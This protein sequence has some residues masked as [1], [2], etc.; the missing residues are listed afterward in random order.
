MTGTGAEVSE[1]KKVLGALD[2]VMLGLGAMIGTGIFVLTGI[3]AVAAGPALAISFILAASA[4]ALAALCYAEFASMIPVAGSAYTYSYATLGELIAWI[5]GWSLIAEYG[6]ATAA[7]SVGWS[8]YFQALLAGFGLQLPAALSAAPGVDAAGTTTLFNLPAFVIMMVITAIL[9][10]GIHESKR[11]NNL[12]VIIKLIVVIL[13]IAVGGWYV[14][15]ENFEPYAPHGLSGIVSA[16]AL[17]FFAFLGFDAVSSAAEE[18]RRPQRDLPIG[19]IGSLL[20]C[21]LL[22]A[23]VAT[24]ATGI[25]PF[26]DFKGVDEPI[27]LV[28]QRAG[29]DW[30]AGLVSLAAVSGMMT[31]IL[32]MGYG[33]T[34]VVFAMS[35][36]GLLPGWLSRIDQRQVPVASTWLLGT[37]SA[38]IAATI[39]LTT[40]AELINM[41][42]LLAFTIISLSVP[43]LRRTRPDL[44]RAFR[45]PLPWVLGPLSVVICLILMLN[46]A[47]ETWFAFLIWLLVGLA[48]YFG[49]SRH[50]ARHENLY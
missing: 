46:L 8:G 26:Q 42:T 43:I 21:A 9:A 29:I 10:L 16:A 25:V 5:V 6:L 38:L 35:R 40:L 14:K 24:V 4:C 15:P 20:I 41:G 47:F 31:V 3:G 12:L 7:V 48:C 32:V 2:L 45:V 23:L 22:Y 1:L 27:A 19:L 18:V 36:D 39:P 49:Y 17:V 37:I 50:H 11:V 13:V 30:L 28:F 44:Q 33:L 34:R